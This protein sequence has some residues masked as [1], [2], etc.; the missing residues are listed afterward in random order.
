MK[1]NALIF[2]M[3]ICMMSVGSAYAQ[4]APA[5]RPL[6][7]PTKLEIAAVEIVHKNPVLRDIGGKLRA[8]LLNRGLNTPEGVRQRIKAIV[9]ASSIGIGLSSVDSIIP[10]EAEIAMTAKEIR[11]RLNAQNSY[12]SVHNQ[13]QGDKMGALAFM[14]MLNEGTCSLAGAIAPQ[15]NQWS[16][17]EIVFVDNAEK[18]LGE[19]E[20]SLLFFAPRNGFRSVELVRELI[21]S[22][23]LELVQAV[24]SLL[25]EMNPRLLES[26]HK[27]AEDGDITSDEVDATLGCL[28]F[29]SVRG[30]AKRMG[31]PGPGEIAEKVTLACNSTFTGREVSPEALTACGI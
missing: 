17:K 4:R 18:L 9:A 25:E 26:M 3:A 1:W 8:D 2:G 11:E 7:S 14:S 13:D 16:S 28:V 31:Y 19:Y 12:A 22:G 30:L 23:D 15:S 10:T 20:N 24:A 5:A 21:R 29:E 6:R 27:A